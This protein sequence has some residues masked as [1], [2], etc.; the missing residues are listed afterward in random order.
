VN[1]ENICAR[2]NI[3]YSLHPWISSSFSIVSL[4]WKPHLTQEGTT[5]APLVIVSCKSKM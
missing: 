2:D 5:L 4:K 1:S 3:K